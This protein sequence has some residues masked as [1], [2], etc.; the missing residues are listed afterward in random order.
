[1]KIVILLSVLIIASMAA[2]IALAIPGVHH[3]IVIPG[4]VIALVSTAIFFEASQ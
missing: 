3:W 1:M 2:G 4:G